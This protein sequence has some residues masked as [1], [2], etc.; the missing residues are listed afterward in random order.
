LLEIANLSKLF[1]TEL[2]KLG[3]NGMANVI[4]AVLMHPLPSTA[5]FGKEEQAVL[6][7]GIQIMD[8][9]NTVN[10]LMVAEPTK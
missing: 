10:L 9:K 8:K 7:K 1:K 5:I 3:K 6:D 4:S 2:K